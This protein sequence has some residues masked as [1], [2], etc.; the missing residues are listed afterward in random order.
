MI[1][2]SLQIQEI[3]K[4]ALQEDLGWGDITTQALFPFK[5][6]AKGIIFP[7]EEM[8]LAGGSVVKELFS[9]LDPEVA[10]NLHKKDGMKIKKGEKMITLLGDG[11][12]LLKG[13][14]VALNFLQ[15][16]SGIATLTTQYVNLV[17]GTPA[18]I[19]DTR[20]TTPG[21]RILERYAVAQGGGKNHR[22]HLGDAILIKDN[23]IAL[24]RG[25]KSVLK[26]IRSASHSYAP[27]EIEVKNL[28]EVKLALAA[29]VD[30]ILLDNM[31]PPEIRKAVKLINGS[32]FIEASGGINLFNV[33]EIAETGVDFISIGAL[34]HSARAIDISMDIKRV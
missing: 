33:R 20:K 32:A 3:L 15:R 22:F 1:L 5:V 17:K 34:T 23:H 28:K 29:G 8:V 26:S 10:V 7:K 12:S 25:L 31:K 19:L 6:K 18:R 11:R 4:A 30:I 24:A 21:L 16:L 2:H 14:R 9:I 13:E 27:L